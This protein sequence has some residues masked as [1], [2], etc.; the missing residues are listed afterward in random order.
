MKT[1][2]ALLGALLALAATPAA[3]GASSCLA[4]PSGLAGWWPGD[5]NANDIA[6]TNNGTLQGGAT[7]TAA[8]KVAQAFSFDGTNGYVQI[9]NNAALQPTNLTIEAWVLFSSLD[10]AASGGSPPGQQYIVFKQNTRSSNFEGFYLGKERGATGDIFVFGV[11]SSSGQAVEV[12]SSP[13]IATGVWYHV[14]GVRGP[15]SI[16][17][18]TNGQLVGQTSVSF[19]QNYGNFPLYFGTS[20]ES[21]WD[22]KLKGLLD[23]VSLYN[24]ALSSNEV[25][26]IYAAGVAGKC[27]AVNGLTITTQPQSQGVAV[28]SNAVFTVAA[29][30]AAPLS[31]QWCFTG[32]AIAGATNTN[33]ALLDIQPANG[34]SYTVVVTNLAA[35]ATSAVAVL[36]VLLPPVI[37]VQPQSLT[38]VTGTTASFSATATGSAPLGYQWQLNG[39]SLAN[40]GRISGAKTNTLSITNVQP[41]DAGSYTLVVSNAAGIATSAVA[42]LTVTG[43]PAITAQP[44]SQSV[45]AGANVSFSVTASGTAPLSYQWQFNGANLSGATSTSLTLAG[46]QPANGGNYSVMVTNPAGSVTSAVAVLTVLVPPVITTQPQSLTNVAGTT[47]TFSATATG[48]APLSYQWQ[49]NGVN[50]VNAGRISGATGATLTIT[51]V[52]L[53]D[54]GSYTIGASNAAG[55]ATSTPAILTVI[56]LPVITTQPVSQSVNVGTNASFSVTASGTS[57]LSYRWSFNGANLADG[58]QF[59][60]TASA[61]LSIANAQ[62][63]NA[64]GYSVVVTNTLGS[65]TSTLASLIVIVPGSCLAPPANL[66]GWWPGEGNANDI[67]GT[68]NGILEGGATANAVGEVGRAFSFDGTNGYVQ[69]PDSPV[70]HPTNLTVECWVRFASL[71]SAVSG[72][73]AQGEQ[74]IVFKQNSRYGNFEGFDLSKI[75]VAGGDVFKFLVTSATAQTVELHATTLVSTGV[76]YHVAGMRGTNFAQIYVN[77]NL[78]SQTNVSFPQDYGTLPLYFGTSGQAYWDCKLNGTLDEVSLYNRALSSNEVAAIYAAGSA[79]KCKAVSGANITAQP[80]SQTVATGSNALFTVTA[81][82]TAPLSYQWQFNG[83]AMAGDTNANLTLANAQPANAGNY[84]VIVTNSA[85]SVASAVAVL[86]VLSP[87][88][89]TTQPQSLTSAAGTAASFSATATGSAPLSYQWQLNGVNLANGG[90]IIGATTNTLTISG[91]QPAD[92]GSYTL[93]VSNAAGIVTS[94]VAVLTV[95]GPPAILTQPVSQ[96]VVA[97]ANVSFSLTASG[98]AP[99]SYQWQ[100]NGANLSG[101]VSTS[102][103]L[104]GVQPANAG[105]YTVVVTNSSGSATSAA[106]VLTVQASAGTV[107]IN[108]ALTYQTIDGFG[109][110]ANHRSWTNNELEPVLDALIDQAGMTLFRVVY[111]NADWETNNENL[112]PTVTNW[113]YFSMIYSNTP[114]FQA[115]WGIMAYLNQKGITNGLMPNFQG[116]GPAWMSSDYSLVHG[117]ENAWAEMIASA[118]VYARYTNH[119]Q[120]TLVGPNNEPDIPGSGIGTTAAQYV[121]TL[122]DLSQQLDTNGMEDVRFVGPDLSSSGT[123]W[124]P[125]LM[126]DPVVMGKLAHFGLH[127]YAQN[128]AWSA[129]VYNFLQESAY[130]DITFWMTEFNVWCA[131]CQA[132]IS[133]TNNWDYF[134]GTAEYLLADLANGSSAGLVWEGYDSIYRQNYNDAEHWSFWGLFAVNDT[135]AVPKTYTARKNFYTLSQITAFVRPGAQQIDVSGSVSLEYLLAFYNTNNGQLTLTGVNDTSSASSLS[136]ALTSL[137]AIPSLDLYYTSSTTNLCYG[138][139]VAVNNGTFSVTVPADCVFTLTYTNTVAGQTVPLVISQAPHFLTPFAQ[140]GNLFLTLVGASGSACL[141]EASSDLLNWFEVTNVTLLDGTATISAPMTAGHQFY[142]ATLLP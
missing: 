115:L 81:G 40:G 56:A 15:S 90:R 68:N 16:Q 100:F 84:A 55:V 124:M 36:T 103:T 17:L 95:T 19:A 43:P 12:D 61:T 27:K 86:T 49:L 125:N 65:V 14:A 25:A 133:G 107:I 78:E 111:D 109:V 21:Y 112:G 6:S 39:V 83:A 110:N 121:L 136:C 59:L 89:I 85:A 38:N 1:L 134:R 74:F 53:A 122:H 42:F 106:A 137:P 3:F 51:S 130:P 117:Y 98:T 99:L 114:D 48:S 101:A 32:V 120:F 88:A 135:N 4:P 11:S 33:L 66:T 128:G 31:Y 138:G 60:G 82:G 94:A 57:P 58:G 2:P 29:A 126:S 34:G 79:G 80:Q 105:S 73:A 119:L 76:W 44:A 93:V 91:L 18:Y 96:S 75:R 116:F 108:G 23:E 72:G 30:G 13:M 118:L 71:D 142:R 52:Q 63:T 9:P 50:L 131:V 129:G 139:S 69:I 67:T 22:H 24:R 62:T 77:G 37:T 28:G 5:G 70:F 102:L 113:P 54:A 127:S 64:G 104:A 141:I 123:N 45:V 132:G 140:N 92:A 87:P 47:A 97:G 10:S 46:V 41:A 20:G 35:S 7:A 8:G 26:A